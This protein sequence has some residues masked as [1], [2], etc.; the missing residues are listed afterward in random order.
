MVLPSLLSPVVLAEL[1]I[2]EYC[3]VVYSFHAC[4]LMVLAIHAFGLGGIFVRNMFL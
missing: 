3:D 2:S 1:S 4:M